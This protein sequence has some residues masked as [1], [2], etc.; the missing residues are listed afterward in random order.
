LVVATGAVLLGTIYP[1]VIDALNLGKLSVGAPYFNAVFVPLLAPLLFLMVP[2]VAAS[3]KEAHLAQLAYRL[4]WV[5]LGA[6]LLACAVPAYLETRGQ[7]EWLWSSS[8]GILLSAWITLG[9]LQ[10]VVLR[11][12][13][14]GRPP[15]SYWGMQVAHLG[16]A[17]LVLGI[18]MV[19][20]YE[21]ERDV[22][23]GIGET[24]TL[25]DFTFELKRV[26]QVDGVNYKAS[27]ATL[28]LKKDQRTIGELRPE[29]RNYFSTSMPMTEAA[30]DLGLFR[31][32]YVSLGD[33]VEPHPQTKAPRWNLRVY[34]K[35]FIS[36]IWAGA[37]LMVF[38]GLMAAMDKRYRR[39][40]ARDATA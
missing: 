2:G 22:R 13:Q 11:L 16:M 1:L 5:A 3:W 29:K 14:S 20:G 8:L 19:K 21:L 35:P 10:H 15:L 24:V 27:R 12:R 18:T 32:L 40:T 17:V 4:R 33:P 26:E 25:R 30:V 31:D 36:W 6:I 34:D 23:I 9:S 38:G 37:L 7:G 39:K 28:E